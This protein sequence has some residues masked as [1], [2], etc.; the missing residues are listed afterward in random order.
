MKTSIPINSPLHETFRALGHGSNLA[1]VQVL[2][3]A[4]ASRVV[5]VRQLA[6]QTLIHR[7]GEAEMST[8]LE[9]IDNCNEAELP[10]LT[11]HTSSLIVPIEI[12]LGDRNP[13]KRQRSLCAIAKLQI[14]SQFH[15][16]V[17]AAQ[18]PDDPQQIV[19]AELV[20]GLACKL[21]AEAR[22]QKGRSSN[23]NRE[24]LLLDLWQSML[25]FND[26]KILQIV[27]A[28]LCASHWDDPAFKDLF[29]PTRSDPIYKFAL[30]Q[31]K[32]SHRTQI[33]ELMA[34]VL[35]SQGPSP[36]AVQELGER[37]EQVMAMQLA[38]FVTMFGFTP[39]VTKNLALKIPIQCIERLDF[40]NNSLS[41]V[42]RC[43]LVQLLA[44]SDV[45]P[46]KI[47]FG[48]T[49]L[50]E[51]RDSVVDLACSNAIR[52][53]RSL[54]PEIVVMVLSDCFEVPGM[55]AYEPPPWKSSLRAAL[56]R[57]IEMYPHQASMVQKSIEFIFADFRCEELIK[58][59]DDWPESHLNAYAK[60]VRIA[61]VGFVEFIERDAQSPSA[62]KRSRA[63]HAVRFLG[64]D[65]GLADITL[66]AIEDKSEK[67]RIEAIYAIA[68][69]R[70]RND[71]IEVLRPLIR[72]E[73]QS[74][75]TAAGF[76]LS[77]LGI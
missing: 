74:V 25:Q 47:I 56:E 71:A 23:T 33:T 53:I 50:L 60:I 21:G 55:K 72:D 30:R 40:S 34:G 13:L 70:N 20:L 32:H 39:M 49:K 8:I 54:K 45:S 10:F 38:E 31:L 58:H 19:A 3:Q 15:H 7:G 22:R 16:L 17:R 62:V 24:R 35:W 2:G 44:A 9:R 11:N 69:G 1:S 29:K 64:M 57:L 52:S 73:D 41:L 42:H 51:T 61:E 18:S 46:D 28:W 5:A 77:G 68:S 76:A 65:N 48:I 75:K 36:E 59:L 37:T 63:I 67:V 4:L 26:H 14:A 43:A 6:L 66:E 12:G 27:D